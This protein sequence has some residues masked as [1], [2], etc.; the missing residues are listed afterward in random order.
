MIAKLERTQR[1]TA[2]N[3]DPT[4][5]TK[6]QWKQ[7]LINEQIKIYSQAYIMRLGRFLI[8]QE[9]SLGA[10]SNSVCH[11][12][13]HIPPLKKEIRQNTKIRPLIQTKCTSIGTELYAKDF[14][15]S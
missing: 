2:H 3:M 15:F 14:I 13:V 1:S 12:H 8:F 6:I 9:T 5:N 4:Q 7:Q 10:K 11:A